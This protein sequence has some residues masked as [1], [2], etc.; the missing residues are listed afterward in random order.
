MYRLKHLYLPESTLQ[1]SARATESTFQASTRSYLKYIEVV[2]KKSAPNGDNSAL[3]SGIPE[4]NLRESVFDEQFKKDLEYWKNAN[5]KKLDRIYK[6]IEAIIRDPF[7]GEGYPK[8]L[9]Y[10]G[11]NVW[12]RDIDKKHR[13][14]YLVGAN[15]IDFLQARFHYDDK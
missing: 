4:N 12:S 1:A 2:M 3:Q 10:Q 5:P 6:L 14:V 7:K 13:I 11:S 9:K 8:P 15:K